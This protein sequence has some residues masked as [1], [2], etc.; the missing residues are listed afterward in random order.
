MLKVKSALY[1]R[2]LQ[3]QNLSF[4]QC[5]QISTDMMPLMMYL[6]TKEKY[7]SSTSPP[8]W[9]GPNRHDATDDVPLD[10]V[11]VREFNFSLN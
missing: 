6:W 9:S 7:V 4:L 2:M 3:V 8:M 10:K 11:K 1:C 5:G